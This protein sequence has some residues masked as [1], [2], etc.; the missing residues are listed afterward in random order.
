MQNVL[1]VVA[2]DEADE[3][4]GSTTTQLSIHRTDVW[5]VCWASDDPHAFAIM[6]KTKLTI[7]HDLHAEDPI[8][9]DHFLVSFG[10]LEADM[11]DLDALMQDPEVRQLCHLACF[12]PLH[13]DERFRTIDLTNKLCIL[14]VGMHA[15]PL[16]K[17]AHNAASTKLD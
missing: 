7:L 13:A 1:K 2:L 9:T 10:Q 4:T 11:V 12:V 6:D 16:S 15:E 17:A 8:V 3:A 5:D 14:T